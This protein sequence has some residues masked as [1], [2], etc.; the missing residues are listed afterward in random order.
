M[1]TADKQ[2]MDTSMTDPA[3]PVCPR[4][5][6]PAGE[7]RFCGECGLNLAEQSDLPTRSEW[8]AADVAPEHDLPKRQYGYPQSASAGDRLHQI[9]GSL[10]PA[11]RVWNG[12]LGWFHKQPRGGRIALVL[13][14]RS[15]LAS[16]PY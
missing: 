15:C 13:S 7:Q 16:G 4:C 5:E 11:A 14:K 3:A 8:H 10:P 9:G 1:R 6:E 12:F 2:N